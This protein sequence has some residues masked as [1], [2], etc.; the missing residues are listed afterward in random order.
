MNYDYIIAGAGLYGS[1]F[2]H[3]MTKRNKKCL[4]LER[5]NHIGGNLY[6]EHIAGVCVHKYG[7]HIFHTSNKKV[8]DYVNQFTEF[9]PYINSP[10]ANYKGE[11][12]NLP[13]NMN[14]FTK[15]WNDVRTPEE[16]RMRIEEQRAE[17][18]GCMPS[19]LEEQ[20][21]SL[22]GRDIYEKLVR[23]YTQKQ[24][25]KPCKE[26]PAFIIKRLPVRFTF[27]NNY[28][29]DR[30]QGIPLGSYNSI[31]EKLLAGCEIKL[32]TDY[33]KDKKTY[34]SMAR[35]VLYTG[36]ID[37]YFDYCL[38]NL[39]YRSLRFETELLQNTDNYQ[40]N[41][42]INYTDEETPYTRII[43][44]KHFE[45]GGQNDTVITREY[46][47][48]WQKGDEAYYPVNDDRNHTLFL[49]YKEL[50]DQ[51]QKVIFGGR[52]GSYQYYDMDKVIEAAWKA[53]EQELLIG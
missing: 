21:I 46:P 17:L 26:L 23:G 31:I 36:M 24:W 4:V 20:A 6:C 11:L 37:E 41:A 30:Y 40:G 7:A 47:C 15:L 39:E 19:N 14:T 1:V 28:F 52:L 43:E 27:N 2:A 25:G 35:R 9:L 29:N 13:F 44:H 10:I 48:D 16:A 32:G 18:K 5:R 33:L 42:V 3:E 50:A 8:W 22:V 45:F 49:R 12:Y 38:G 53:V 51:E 34:Q